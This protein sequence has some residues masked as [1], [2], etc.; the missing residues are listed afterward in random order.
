MST[1]TVYHILI[2]SDCCV[3][4]GVHLSYSR[5]NSHASNFRIH[6]LSMHSEIENYEN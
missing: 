2:T 6:V 5:T 1:C 3:V 4:I